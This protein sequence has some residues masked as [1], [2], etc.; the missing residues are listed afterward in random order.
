[1][2]SRALGNKAALGDPTSSARPS[3]PSSR[4]LHTSAVAPQLGQRAGVRGLRL[5]SHQNKDGC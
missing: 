1:M 5:C 4:S 3:E 2:M